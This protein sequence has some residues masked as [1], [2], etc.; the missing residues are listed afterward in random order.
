M[1]ACMVLMMIA[2]AGSL[3]FAYNRSM[4]LERSVNVA[5][6]ALQ[7]QEAENATL[8]S[9]LL[10]LFDTA[11]IATFAESRSLVREKNPVYVAVGT[12]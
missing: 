4:N 2:S 3:V 12:Q 5:V 11:H 6:V 8:K 9:S 7:K 1:L 10:S